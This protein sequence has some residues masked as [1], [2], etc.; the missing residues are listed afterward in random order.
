MCDVLLV[1][2]FFLRCLQQRV[3]AAL[4]VVAFCTHKKEEEH[5]APAATTAAATATGRRANHRTTKSV[6]HLLP[7]EDIKFAN[8]HLTLNN[9][10]TEK[11]LFFR[12]CMRIF[13]ERSI[14]IYKVSE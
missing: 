5:I 13:K 9:C 1:T 8:F 12:D 2:L 3:S 11:C 10:R 6:L 4:C 7:V 14:D